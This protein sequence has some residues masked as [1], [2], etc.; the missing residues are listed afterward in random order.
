VKLHTPS[1]PHEGCGEPAIGAADFVP[2]CARFD[3]D[4]TEGP[5]DYVGDTEVH[6]DGQFNA[7]ELATNGSD[8]H[9]LALDPNVP[10]S[11]QIQV[12]CRAGHEWITRF[13]MEGP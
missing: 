3:G 5:V 6:W 7:S 12:Q 2:A 10:A 13:S 9:H 8:D 1:C 11:E 4:P